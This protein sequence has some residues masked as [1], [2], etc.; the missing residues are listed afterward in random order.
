MFPYVTKHARKTHFRACFPTRMC[1][2]INKF[3]LGAGWC[4]PIY[5]EDSSMVAGI[6]KGEMPGFIQQPGEVLITQ[7]RDTHSFL[8]GRLSFLAS[9]V[10]SPGWWQYFASVFYKTGNHSFT[11]NP[12]QELFH[13]SMLV[14]KEEDNMLTCKSTLISSLWIEDKRK[15]YDK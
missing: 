9:Q 2:F 8:V 14:L 5:M 1:I 3:H 15:W 12:L 4:W 11:A 6:K 7:G 10:K 13:Q